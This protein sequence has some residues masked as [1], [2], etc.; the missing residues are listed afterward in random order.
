MVPFRGIGSGFVIDDDSFIVTNNHVV[1]DAAKIGIILG[2]KI[3]N[4]SVKGS[5]RRLDIALIQVEGL[6]LPKL[7]LSDSD[8]LRVGQSVYA[9]GNPLGLEGGP[10]V[11]SGVISAL[12]R[13]IQNKISL[14]GLIQTDA[15]INPGNSGGPLIDLRGKAIGV[16]TAIIPYAQGIGFAIPINSV[17][18]CV[19]Q[20]KLYGYY[21][22]PWIGI[23]GLNLNPQVSRYYNFLVSDGVLITRVVGKS[24]AQKAGIQ[25]GDIIVSFAE[26]LISDVRDLQIEIRKRKPGDNV[27][28]QIVRRRQKISLT[29]KIEGT[30]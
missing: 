12:N 8:K 16:N 2:K 27:S 28:V 5:C 9:I 7:E 20:L 15:A 24:P 13:T 29:L 11:T 3:L 23:E 14:Q 26:T 22:T 19:E 10:T 4:G 30:H 6:D 1:K 21:T 17:K 18:D 25:R